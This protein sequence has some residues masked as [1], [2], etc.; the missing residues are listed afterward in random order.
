MVLKYLLSEYEVTRQFQDE[1]NKA[2]G[3]QCKKILNAVKE[4]NPVLTGRSRD[5]WKLTSLG[6]E[7]DV[8]YVEELD[9]RTHF[10]DRAL[11][12]IGFRRL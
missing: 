7:N 6:L 8:E 5:G 2:Y 11:M 1:V 10:I 9:E 12:K 4:E 3:K